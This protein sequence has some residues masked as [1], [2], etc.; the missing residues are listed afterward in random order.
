MIDVSKNV[1]T[2]MGAALMLA[3]L[4]GCE[5]ES[6]SEDTGTGMTDGITSTSTTPGNGRS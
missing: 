3:V 4:A 6:K 1:S 2:M 5:G